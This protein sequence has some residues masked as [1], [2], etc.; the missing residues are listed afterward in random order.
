[1]L[2]GSWDGLKVFSGL[3]RFSSFIPSINTLLLITVIWENWIRI[4]LMAGFCEYYAEASEFVEVCNLLTTW[5]SM[6]CVINTMCHG[7]G[8]EHSLL[9]L[10][11]LAE[12]CL[13]NISGILF[14]LNAKVGTHFSFH[15]FKKY[16]MCSKQGSI[17]QMCVYVC[18]CICL[19]AVNGFHDPVVPLI[20][21]SYLFFRTDCM[22]HTE[23]MLSLWP[24]DGHA[25][26]P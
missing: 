16:Y 18:V 23:L 25:A 26:F 10:T 20:N 13:I 9:K 17:S 14:Y 22:Y 19:H 5:I 3:S 4:W 11:E 12:T 24:L 21:H 8:C 1:M 7:V 6:N 2:L 15:C